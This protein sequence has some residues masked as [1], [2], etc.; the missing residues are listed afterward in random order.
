M[1]LIQ[2]HTNSFWLNERCDSFFVNQL[3]TIFSRKVGYTCTSSHETPMSGSPGVLPC[4]VS[5][6][7]FAKVGGTAPT[8]KKPVDPG[9]S[10]PPFGW[11][12]LDLQMVHGTHDNLEKSI[13]NLF[14]L[15]QP[16]FN[17]V[18]VFASIFMNVSILNSPWSRWKKTVFMLI[19]TF[20]FQLYCH[21]CWFILTRKCYL[22]CSHQIAWICCPE[23]TRRLREVPQDQRQPPNNPTVPGCTVYTGKPKQD[24]KFRVLMKSWQDPIPSLDDIILI[25][26]YCVY[27]IWNIKMLELMFFIGL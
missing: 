13:M 19:A 10:P 27:N 22:R 6:V 20:P 9:V 15:V 1:N 26:T 11:E 2:T 5:W 17:N 12:K 16:C 21:P 3:I 7:Y 4:W 25:N 23:A 8:C 14:Q 24:R 18:R